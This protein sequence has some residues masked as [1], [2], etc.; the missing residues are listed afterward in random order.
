MSVALCLGDL[1]LLDLSTYIVSP[2]RAV[3]SVTLPFSGLFKV[4]SG[5]LYLPL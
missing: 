2:F 3:R 5:F 1:P 4:L